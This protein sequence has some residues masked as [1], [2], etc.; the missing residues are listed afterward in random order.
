LA[1]AC[2]PSRQEKNRVD[3]TLFK[4]LIRWVVRIIVGAG[5]FGTYILAAVVGAEMLRRSH[6]APWLYALASVS[7]VAVFPLA[8]YLYLFV[9]SRALA[10]LFPDEGIEPFPGGTHRW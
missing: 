3:L 4:P 10:M 9:S 5:F 2:T 6:S 7:A 1:D 8:L